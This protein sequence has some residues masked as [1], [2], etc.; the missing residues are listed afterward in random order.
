MTLRPTRIAYVTG[1][2]VALAAPAALAPVLF[3]AS[4][5]AQ[6][7]PIAARQ[8]IMKGV[9]NAT[10]TGVQMIRGEAPFDL[11]TARETFAVY[12]DASERMPGLFPEGTETGG[13]T[14]AAPAIWEDK[15]GFD[16]LFVE[17]GE[18]AAAGLEATTDQASFQAAL[19]TATQSCRTC[20]EQFRLDN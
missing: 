4:A 17:F 15:E 9:G 11:D 10:R 12:I 20:H 16:A 2:A 3:A 18:R 6:G 13:D 19:G 8:E 5:L 1:L 7:E 14:K